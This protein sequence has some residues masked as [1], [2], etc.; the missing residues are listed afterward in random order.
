MNS[1]SELRTLRVES[2]AHLGA[3]I[4]RDDGKV[5]FVPYTVPGDVVRARLIEDKPRFARAVLEEVIEPS[6]H[7]VEPLC[8]YF[9]DC[10]GCQWQHI[11]YPM[12][13]QYKSRI[14]G[15]Q[16]EHVG[17]LT[18][19][20]V[21]ET[22]GMADPWGY[23]NSARLTVGS[24]GTLGF[25]RAESHEV[26]AVEDC[27]ILHPSLRELLR[28][29]DVEFPELMALTLR[30]GVRTGERMVVLETAGDEPPEIEVDIP[31]S[32]ALALEDGSVATLIGE[33]AI[34]EVVAGRRYR[35]SPTSFFQV[36]TVGAER[37]VEVV[38]RALDPQG[39][40][41]LLDLYCGVGLFG[42]SLAGRVGEVV[43]VESAPSAVADALANAEGMDNVTLVEGLVEEALPQLEGGFDLAVVDPPRGGMDPAALGALVEK[44]PR[45]IAYVSCE[46]TTLARDCAA[47]VGAGYR[48]RWVQPVDM[49]PQTYH[50]ESVALLE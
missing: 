17:K 5:V 31:V 20:D 21:C 3:G 23:R 6:P 22:V 38:A 27:L 32:C 30:A 25:Q 50:I 34:H 47:L 43:G 48:L 11:A 39:W 12:Q 15:E 8:P 46:P 36:N 19:V 33:T 49:F 9:G 40:E 18:G 41:R 10:G 44:R 42:L 24:D 45:R 29:L 28:T 7:R 16:L 1:E 13:T 37:L 35:I 4:A 14:M 2:L 26:V